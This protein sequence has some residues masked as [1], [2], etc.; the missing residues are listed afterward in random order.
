M[1]D[2]DQRF[3]VIGISCVSG[4]RH[5]AIV[6]NNCLIWHVCDLANMRRGNYHM[7]IADAT[8][9]VIKPGAHYVTR[10]GLPK[11]DVLKGTSPSRRN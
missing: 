1:H 11:G 8:G 7:D 10:G 9:E 4:F 5:F 3:G 6:E 2:T